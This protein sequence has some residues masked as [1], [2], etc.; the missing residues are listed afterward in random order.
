MTLKAHVA[1]VAGH[2]L[3]E[4]VLFFLRLCPIGQDGGLLQGHG[5]L[6]V[7]RL[8]LVDADEGLLHGDGPLEHG[9]HDGVIAPVAEAAD[10]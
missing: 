4:D 7:V 5:P 6:H 2:Q 9:F 8:A 3:A 10:V 1:C